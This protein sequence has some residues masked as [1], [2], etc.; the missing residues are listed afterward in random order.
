MLTKSM[1]PSFCPFGGSQYLSIFV[2]SKIFQLQLRVSK[3]EGQG[4]SINYVVSK[5]AIFDP[6][7]CRLLSKV[8]L[9]NRLWAYPPPF[10]DDIVYGWPLI[11]N[12]CMLCVVLALTSWFH[13]FQFDAL[14]PFMCYVITCVGNFGCR[15]FL[16]T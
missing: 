7:P 11:M 6:L 15:Y 5:S 13:E 1:K 10:R 2:P 4:P 9:L 8:Y 16:T 12:L 3:K 14:G